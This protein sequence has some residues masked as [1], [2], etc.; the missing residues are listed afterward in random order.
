MQATYVTVVWSGLLAACGAQER[1]A[2][3]TA[4]KA[5]VQHWKKKLGRTA[6][7]CGNARQGTVSATCA[8][9]RLFE[10]MHAALGVCRPAHA[11]WFTLT[12]EGDAIRT[13]YF[14]VDKSGTCTFVVV[15]DRSADPLAKPPVTEQECRSASWKPE[16]DNPSCQILSPVDCGRGV[17]GP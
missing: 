14:V 16:P 17:H 3:E 8:P 2:P 4:P 9:Q 13:D 5:A 6:Q 1:V 15:T 12:G 10:C 7:D 11:V